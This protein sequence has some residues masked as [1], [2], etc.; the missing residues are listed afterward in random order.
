MKVQNSSDYYV[1]K[2][3]NKWCVVGKKDN[4]VYKECD[5]DKEAWKYIDDAMDSGE[6]PYHNA[7]FQNGV[8]KAEQEIKN[9]LANSFGGVPGY[10]TAG[11]GRPDNVPAAHGDSS[12]FKIGDMV[13]YWKSGHSSKQTGKIKKIDDKGWIHIEGNEG[14]AVGASSITK[15]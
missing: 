14:V 10:G 1:A 13:S 6:L 7:A 15:I 3:G 12:K 11:K 8:M 5:S 2:R 9:K 4:K